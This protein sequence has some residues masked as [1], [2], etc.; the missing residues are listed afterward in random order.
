L[1]DGGAETTH[2]NRKLNRAEDATAKRGAELARKKENQ[3]L[4]EEEM[5]AAV[6]KPK[7]KKGNAASAKVSR[8]QI[9]AAQ[10]AAL[11]SQNNKHKK[12]SSKVVVQS[13]ELADNI[14]RLGTVV[15][16]WPWQPVYKKT[17]LWTGFLFKSS[18]SRQVSRYRLFSTV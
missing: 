6:G 11:E 15:N 3:L 17:G 16:S 9:L 1:D 2:V 7:S 5:A 12:G 14:N 13:E 4:Y 8:A 18:L 10:Q